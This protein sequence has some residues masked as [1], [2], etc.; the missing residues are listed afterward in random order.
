LEAELRVIFVTL[1]FVAF[2]TMSAQAAP[3]IPLK[4]SP[5]ELGVAPS[6]EL[7]RDGCGYA[8]HRVLWQDVWGNWYWGRCVPN[9]WGKGAFLPP[10][11]EGYDD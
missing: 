6:I 10:P 4:G 8:Y 11:D 9:W 1:G 2:A 7:V 3:G 5:V